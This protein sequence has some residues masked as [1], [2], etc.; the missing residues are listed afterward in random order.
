MFAERLEATLSNPALASPS[1][2]ARLA[3]SDEADPK[4]VS[5]VLSHI[6]DQCTTRRSIDPLFRFMEASLA[7]IP[8][9]LKI[10]LWR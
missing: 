3:T 5:T 6:T 4:T 9:S 7:V 8:V 1:R 10:S 2:L